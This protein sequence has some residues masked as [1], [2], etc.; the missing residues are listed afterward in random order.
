MGL[1]ANARQAAL[2]FI[3]VVFLQ[4]DGDDGAADWAK[5]RPCSRYAETADTVLAFL[6]RVRVERFRRRHSRQHGLPD[7]IA[8][9]NYAAKTAVNLALWMGS[10]DD[11][12]TIYYHLKLGF[13]EAGKSLPSAIGIGSSG[14]H[15]QKVAGAR[16]TPILKN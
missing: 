3:P 16:L 14:N 8:P 4:L 5:Q 10:L 2:I 9:G 13:P 6:K 7:S 1:P 11:W 12:T 15:P